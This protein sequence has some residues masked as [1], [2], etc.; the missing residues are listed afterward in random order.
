MQHNFQNIDEQIDLFLAGMLKDGMLHQFEQQMD[1]NVDLCIK[2]EE[3]KRFNSL[4]NKTRVDRENILLLHH[5]LDDVTS[6]STEYNE[7][8]I[9]NPD[10]VE[11]ETIYANLKSELDSIKTPRRIR[12]T[13]VVTYAIS[14]VAAIGLILLG[15]NIL[16]PNTQPKNTSIAV[17]SVENVSNPNIVLSLPKTTEKEQKIHKHETQ[18]SIREL[19]LQYAQK[20]QNGS[21]DEL[22]TWANTQD[23]ILPDA[24]AENFSLS[25]RVSATFRNPALEIIQPEK[26]AVT[27]NP[28]SFDCKGASGTL[29]ISIYDNTQTQVW[30][31]KLDNNGA[32]TCDKTLKQG[33][34]Y[35]IF[36]LETGN[37]KQQS[38]RQFFVVD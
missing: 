36:R 29:Y 1:N 15:I 16:F 3:R 37:Q 25:Q 10:L 9:L 18:L 11:R 26:F 4:L 35:C 32:V 13:S 12:L 38:I 33:T 6:S 21:N 30:Q 2:I 22:V 27:Q 7:A 8:K 17:A 20:K 14:S 24:F 5:K 34:Y 19:V 31:T 28:L 23:I